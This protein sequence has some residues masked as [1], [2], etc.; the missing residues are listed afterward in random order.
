MGSASVAALL[1]MNGD[2]LAKTPLPSFAADGVRSWI[3]ESQGAA[4]AEAA[5]IGAALLL[6]WTLATFGGAILAFGR[7]DLGAE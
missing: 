3:W 2:Q 1:T 7:Q 5:L 6:G 4:S